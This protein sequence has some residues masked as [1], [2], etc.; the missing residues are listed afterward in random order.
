M[1]PTPGQV[2][3]HRDE[4]H[5][6]VHFTVTTFTDKEWGYG[7]ESPNV[8]D[9]S[10]CDVVGMVRNLKAGGFTGVILTAKHHDGFCLWPTETTDHNISASPYKNGQG[11]LVREFA[12]ACKAEGMKFGVY[13][14]PWDRHDA[15]YG[16]PAYV[17]E[18]YRPQLRELLTNYGD[19]FEVW[20]DGANGGDG[21]YGGARE[22]RS[23][24]RTTYYD[25]PTTW[26]MVRE[27]QPDAVMFS[28]VGPG[29][30]W[31]GNERGIAG[32]T[33]WSTI[34]YGDNTGPGQ[35]DTA[36]LPTGTRFGERWIPA[37]CDVSIRPGWFY[38]AAEDERV[39]TPAQ[40]MDLYLKS[41]GRGATFL[42][43][44]PPTPKGQFHERDIESLEQFGEHLAA[45]FD[46]NLADD[47]EAI[48]SNVR[49]GVPTFGPANLLD[50]DLDSA[51][52]TDDDV[53]T[54]SVEIRLVTEKTFNLIRLR[55]AITL[56]QRV[57]GVAIEA[58]I[59]GDWSEIAAAESVGNARL[60]RVPATTTDRIRIRVTDSPVCP[61]LSDFGL[62]LE[63][64]MQS[65]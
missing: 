39:K 10:D 46:D 50:D 65:E 12:A 48:A 60:W 16:A 28:D 44:V 59:E 25:W 45:T 37:E 53:T 29:C 30:R 33:S 35:V 43:N 13:L 27:L 8:F 24:D 47:A 11:D 62:F 58:W 38:H 51:W 34:T 54:P 23:I 61:A 9:P 22:T 56:G 32:E 7:D 1:T 17:T 19:I 18:V 6:F 55:E 49:G 31:V 14:S 57:G 2:A 41:V 63:P 52:I 5:A 26:E 21:Y 3:W 42:L 64:T 20:F 40:L 15:R 36:L 4:L